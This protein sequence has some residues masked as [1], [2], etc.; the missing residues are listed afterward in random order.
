MRSNECDMGSVSRRLN[1]SAVIVLNG[2]E[3]MEQTCGRSPSETQVRMIAG[4][5]TPESHRSKSGVG[6][7]TSRPRPETVSIHNNEEP[8]SLNLRNSFGR[9]EIKR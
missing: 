1:S 9:I 8:T 5:S 3:D 4:C 7:A 2:S 6:R